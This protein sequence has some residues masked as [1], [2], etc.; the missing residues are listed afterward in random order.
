MNPIEITF[1]T[2]LRKEIEMTQNELIMK[3]AQ[4]SGVS[5]KDVEHVLKIAGDV[6]GATLIEETEVVLP[7]LGKLVCQQKAAREARNPQTGEAMMIPAHKAV[8]FRAFKAL[9]DALAA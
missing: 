6:I 9:K 7:G 5:R 1:F 2:T 4:V 8:K 3:T